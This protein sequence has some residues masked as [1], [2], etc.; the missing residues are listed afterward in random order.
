[1]NYSE[2]VKEALKGSIKK[3]EAIIAGTEVDGGTENCPLCQMFHNK[4]YSSSYCNNCLI[5][6]KTKRK[7]CDGTPYEKWASHHA[8][9]HDI[10]FPPFII[11]RRCKKCRKLAKKEL[12]FLKNLL[13][14]M[15]AHSI[16]GFRK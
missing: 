9:C 16:Q 15:E 6:E 11:V 3:W 4:S 14:E 7:Y 13:K 5:Y 10:Y 8:S 1:M 12:D 2:E